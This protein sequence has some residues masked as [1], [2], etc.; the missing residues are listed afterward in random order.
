MDVDAHLGGEPV[1]VARP[2]GR[3][4]APSENGAVVGI[5]GDQ[6]TYR[7]QWLRN[8]TP[9][10]GATNATLDLAQAGNGDNGDTDS[11][12]RKPRNKRHGR[13]R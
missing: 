3:Q 4:R 8:G 9:I 1:S 13:P 10:S 12:E 6:L 5:D 7:Y 2:E 11:K